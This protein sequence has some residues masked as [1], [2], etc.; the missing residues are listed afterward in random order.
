[1]DPENKLFDQEIVPQF[2]D[3]DFIPMNFD[4]DVQVPSVP[5]A[6]A[7]SAQDG[8]QNPQNPN[9]PAN[10][11]AA[12]EDQNQDIV[13]NDDISGLKPLDETDKTIEELKAK[14]YNVTKSEENETDKKTELEINQLQ[15]TIESADKFLQKPHLDLIK[16]KFETDKAS[17]YRAVGKEALIGS[18]VFNIE[19]EAELSRFEDD[20]VIAEIM[21]DKIRN[22]VKETVVKQSKERLN[23]I[24]SEIEKKFTEKQNANK[25]NL[26]TSLKK[27]HAD[28]FLN[29]KPTGEELNEVYQNFISGNFAKSVKDNPDV[30]V[31]FALFQ[32]YKTQLLEAF[33]GGTYGKGVADAV[34]TIQGDQKPT[35]FGTAL[36]PQNSSEKSKNNS[37]WSSVIAENDDRLKDKV[38][39]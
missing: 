7:N 23:A 14:G 33:G 8:N 16:I 18:E 9:A 1:M 34:K 11:P 24:N 39:I 29:F 25:Q 27:Y 2:E 30:M 21:A 36:N 13:F 19:V 37:N 6:D 5:G 31:E 3:S 32:K 17:Q 20:P 35:H 15:K 38:V 4:N 10:P 12:G 22:E 26:Q 28:G